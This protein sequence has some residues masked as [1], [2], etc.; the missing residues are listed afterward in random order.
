[1]GAVASLV[2]F[3]LFYWSITAACSY[4][5]H[6]PVYNTWLGPWPLL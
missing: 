6:I 3:H 1:M 5:Y 4:I 2:Y